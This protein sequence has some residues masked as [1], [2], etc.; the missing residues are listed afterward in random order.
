MI[1]ELVFNKVEK[2]LRF[3]MRRQTTQNLIVPLSCWNAEMTC[4]Y[5]LGR[6]LGRG[7]LSWYVF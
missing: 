3:C 7:I 2:M 1:V 6:K 4:W 5:F